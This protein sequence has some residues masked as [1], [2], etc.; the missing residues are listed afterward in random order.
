MQNILIGALIDGC[1]DNSIARSIIGHEPNTFNEAL[2]LATSKQ[3]AARHYEIRRGNDE[4]VAINALKIVLRT[5][6]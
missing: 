2:E 6:G 1:L 3:R 5:R 4:P